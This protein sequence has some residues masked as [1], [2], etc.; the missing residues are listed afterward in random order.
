MD[1]SFANDFRLTFPQPSQP[2]EMAWNIEIYMNKVEDMV[3]KIEQWFAPS[4]GI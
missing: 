2:S 3:R 4:S 1:E